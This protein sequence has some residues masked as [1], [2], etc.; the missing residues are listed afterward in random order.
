MTARYFLVRIPDGSGPA[1]VAVSNAAIAPGEELLEVLR[2]AVAALRSYQYGNA[3]PDLAEEVAN[4]AD[5]VL[6]K[7]QG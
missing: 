1:G 3:A 2:S 5:V 4:A 7:V 6:S